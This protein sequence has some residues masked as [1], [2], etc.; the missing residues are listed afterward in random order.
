MAN[1]PFKDLEHT[2]AEHFRLC[3][4][5]AALNLIHHVSQICGSTEAAFEQFPFLVGYNNELAEAGLAGVRS[6]EAISQWLDSLRD[7]EEQATDHLPLR[8]LR[9]ASSLDHPALVLLMSIG[10]IEEDARFGL[11]FEAMQGTPGQHRPTASLLNAWCPPS[12]DGDSRAVLRKLQ[13]MGVVRLINPEAP[14]LDWALEVP[15]VLWDALRGEQHETLAPGLRY[16]SP[17]KLR[18]FDELILPDEIIQWLRQIPA[19]LVSG[20]AQTLVVRG[21]QSNGRRTVLGAIARE[22]GCGVL[23]ANFSDQVKRDD[24]RWRLIGPLAT[25]L[26]ALPVFIFDL[27][28]QETADIPR[29]TA[30]HGASGIVLGKQGG[31][32]QP[33]ALGTLTVTLEIPAPL[34][35]RSHWQQALGE[36]STATLDGISERFRLTSGNIQRAAAMAQSDV[37]LQGRTNITLA[38]VQ[39]ATSNLNRQTLDTLAQRLK[40]FGDWNQ[41]AVGSET[42]IE[43]ENLECRCRHREDLQQAVGTTLAKQLNPGVR[44]LFSGPSGTGKTLGARLLAGALQMDLY[45]LD[46]SMVVNKYIGETEKNLN[47]IFARAEELDVILL[48]DEGDALLTQRTGVQTSNDRYANLETNFLL[49]RLETFEGI[50]IVTTNAGDRID[51]AFQRRMDVVINFSPPTP[52]ERWAIWQMHLPVNHAIDHPFLEEVAG[53]C[54]LS[55]GEIRNAA[56]HAS[57]LAL[58]NGGIVTAAYL[59]AAIQREYRKSGGVCPLRWA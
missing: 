53:R 15:G 37:A 41:L 48:L 39:Q 59:E 50:L 28:P 52:N 32:N 11:V 26:Q 9:E 21:P 27:G 38:D 54:R 33:D 12:S 23:Q 5:A 8:A 19:A 40:N 20:K 57:L 16:L 18:R 45:R 7:W 10:L 13:D 2:P 44:A 51:S 49:Q 36:Q 30:Y 34:L 42:R 31:V 24:D 47:Q 4:Y 1:N 46:L 17:E 6:D 22:L 25:A 55:G 56:L 29:I 43:L 3:F 14:R 58:D 35:R